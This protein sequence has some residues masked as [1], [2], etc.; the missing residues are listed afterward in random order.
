M[1]AALG[2]E[3]SL[4]MDMPTVVGVSKRAEKVNEAP[5][6][7]YV[8]SRDEMKRWGVRQMSEIFAR[9]PGYAFYDLDFA[10]DRTPPVRGLYGTFRSVLAYELL[11]VFDWSWTV[12]APNFV[13]SIE[14]ARGAS[15]VAWGSRAESGV[16]NINLRDDLDGAESSVEKGENRRAAYSFAYGHKFKDAN[17]GDNMF[18]GLYKEQQGYKKYDVSALYP[19]DPQSTWKTNGLDTDTMSLLAKIQYQKMKFLYYKDVLA[20]A[21]RFPLSDKPGA[22]E[23]QVALRTDPY[24]RMESTGYRLDYSIYKSDKFDISAYHQLSDKFFWVELVY[25]SRQT[26]EDSGIMG[27]FHHLLGDKLDINFGGDLVSNQK[28]NAPGWQS[29]WCARRR[30]T[31]ASGTTAPSTGRKPPPRC[32]A[33]GTS[34]CR[35]TSPSRRS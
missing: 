28:T 9:V 15:G 14:V 4:F 20:E 23:A 27:G 26:Q 13:K 25:Q 35:A 17:P 24:Q 30:T 32:S 19:G 11:P 34:T 5:V 22:L 33:S 31:S 1:A 10:G 18:V 2:E 29:S 16:V 8:I 21:E 6:A 7:T 3:E 12:L